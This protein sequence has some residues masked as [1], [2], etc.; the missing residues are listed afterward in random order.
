MTELKGGDQGLRPVME[1]RERGSWEDFD[2]LLR[3]AEEK[4][5]EEYSKITHRYPESPAKESG[6][7]VIPSPPRKQRRPIFDINRR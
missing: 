6:N 2:T 4:E 5:E 3:R 1:P 7:L